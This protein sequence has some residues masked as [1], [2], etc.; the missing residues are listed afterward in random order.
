MF[1]ANEDRTRDFGNMAH[2]DTLQTAVALSLTS[3]L[4]K[5]PSAEEVKGAKKFVEILLNIGEREE[6]P[7][8]QPIARSIA[9]RLP[10]NPNQPPKPTK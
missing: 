3:F 5:E 2:S 6:A 10:P 7:K 9:T 1:L 4:L 8:Q